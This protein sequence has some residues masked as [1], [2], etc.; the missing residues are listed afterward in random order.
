M[1]EFVYIGIV[2]TMLFSLNLLLKLSLSCNG[3][4]NKWL[5]MMYVYKSS[6]GKI[7]N[8]SGGHGVLPFCIRRIWFKLAVTSS[9]QFLPVVAHDK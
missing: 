8:S 1:L 3:F 4:K 5:R 7:G 6:G 2:L 9:N